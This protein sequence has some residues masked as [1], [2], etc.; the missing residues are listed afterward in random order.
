MRFIRERQV[1]QGERYK[2]VDI[3]TYSTEQEK[4]LPR[5]S[6]RRLST[7]KQIAENEKNCRRH[8][9]QLINEN[10]DETCYR[11]DLTYEKEPGSREEAEKDADK[12]I[13][14]LKTLYKKYGVEF[15][16]ILVT[17]GGK[18]KVDGTLTRLHHHV[19]ISGGVPRKEIKAKWKHGRT[20][21]EELETYDDE[22]GFEALAVYFTKHK[23][24]EKNKRLWKGS[25]NLRQPLEVRNDNKYSFRKVAE[26]LRAEEQGE[27]KQLIEKWYKGYSCTSYE[28]KRNPVTW[29]PEIYLKLKKNTS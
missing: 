3:V 6:K 25:K 13:G 14:R 22:N 26:L 24:L 1:I 4:R 9:I 10:F 17:G 29:W 11:L 16:Y 21:C 27:A 5:T 2:D 28:I 8:L 12:M 15:K 19:I 18:P 7:P 23:P 20:S